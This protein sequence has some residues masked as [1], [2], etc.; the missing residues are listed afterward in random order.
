MLKY[1]ASFDLFVS[2]F[3]NTKTIASHLMAHLN[4]QV[5][6]GLGYEWRNP[7]FETLDWVREDEDTDNLKLLLVNIKMSQ[8]Y[9]YTARALLLKKMWIA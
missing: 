3:S 2:K 7:T 4:E 6:F 9:Q 5:G 1:Y 8:E